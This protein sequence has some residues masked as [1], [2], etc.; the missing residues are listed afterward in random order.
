MYSIGIDL[1][2]THTAVGIVDD[3]HHIIAGKSTPTVS[4]NGA[5]ALLDNIAATVKSV[6]ASGDFA[7]SDCK[8]A[9]IGVPGVCDSHCGVVRSANN[10]GWDNIAVSEELRKRL[11]LPV[12]FAN[13]ADCAALG[14]VVAGA[15][16]GAGSALVITLGTGVGGGFIVDGR[17]WSGNH[18]LGG[19]FGH[20][21][22]QADGGALCSC[23][24]RGCWEAYASATALIRQAKEA[25][26]AHPDSA[27]NRIKELS[28][29][30]IYDASASGDAA[31]QAVTAQYAAYVGVGVVN[32]I[33][34][35]FPDVVLLGGGIAGAGDALLSPVRAYVKSHA[36]VGD[37][38]MLPEI[39][40]AALG[41]DAGIVGAAALVR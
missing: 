29:R 19:E 28:G 14:E 34:A 4:K 8:G 15:A 38:E 40:A 6:L 41:S 31:A 22:I 25:A 26:Q 24:K 13:D 17:I 10:I 2:G 3:A 18:G 33:N 32:Y 36:H 7:L 5:A 11:G 37:S 30:T 9:G 35:L 1:G 16:K 27:L 20:M 12:Y 21:C 23:G 39:R